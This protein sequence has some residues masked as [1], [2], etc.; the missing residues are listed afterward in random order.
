M[1]RAPYG[2]MRITFGGYKTLL[3]LGDLK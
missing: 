1:A 3:K 2:E